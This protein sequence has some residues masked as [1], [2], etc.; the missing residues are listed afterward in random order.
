MQESLNADAIFVR[1]LCLYYQDIM[2]KA[3]QHFQQTLRLAP[4]H[5]NA[6]IALKVSGYILNNNSK[7]TSLLETSQT[8]QLCRNGSCLEKAPP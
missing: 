8:R 5:S 7:M 6:R 2:D 3:I 1:G 4:D